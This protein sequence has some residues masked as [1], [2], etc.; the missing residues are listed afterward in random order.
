LPQVRSV[1]IANVVDLN[2]KALSG[3]FGLVL[4]IALCVL[5]AAWTFHHWQAWLLI[6]MLFVSLLGITLYPMKSD[7]RL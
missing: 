2:E 1:R 4:T 5:F 6:F 3:V 7:R